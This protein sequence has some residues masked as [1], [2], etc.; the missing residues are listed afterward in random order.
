MEKKKLYEKRKEAL[1]ELTRKDFE[2]F[3][4]GPTEI[5]YFQ[6]EQEYLRK[7]LRIE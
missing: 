7:I 3:K 4:T 1:F 2:L 6:S 5:I